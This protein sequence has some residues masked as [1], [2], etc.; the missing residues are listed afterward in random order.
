MFKG[1]SEHTRIFPSKIT[2]KRTAFINS[3]LP[4]PMESVFKVKPTS[5]QTPFGAITGMSTSAF[6]INKKFLH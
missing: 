2:S 4:S 5:K 3:Q 1:G 6:L